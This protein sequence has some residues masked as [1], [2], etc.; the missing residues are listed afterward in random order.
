MSVFFNDG[1]VL[2][3]STLKNRGDA[4]DAYNEEDIEQKFYEITERVWEKTKA[5]KVFKGTL[6]LSSTSDLKNLM[7]SLAV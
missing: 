1:K 2:S 7:H 5:E 6:N 3:H 4:E